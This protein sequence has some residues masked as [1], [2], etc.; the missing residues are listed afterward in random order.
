M[1]PFECQHHTLKPWYRRVGC[2]SSPLTQWGYQHL[3]NSVLLLAYGLA[4]LYQFSVWYPTYPT[5]RLCRHVA[6]PALATQTSVVREWRLPHRITMAQPSLRL[7]S[8]AG[9]EP[10]THRLEGDCSIP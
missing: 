3:A 2:F 1:V 4:F 8:L 10:A 5:I 6:S 7:A 9:F